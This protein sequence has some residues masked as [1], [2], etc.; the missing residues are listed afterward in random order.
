MGCATPPERATTRRALAAALQVAQEAS[1]GA[2]PSAE[3]IEAALAVPVAAAG[4]LNWIRQH[5]TD[6]DYY[7]L[8]RKP[9]RGSRAT[10]FLVLADPKQVCLAAPATDGT[11]P[12]NTVR[13]H[14][15]HRRTATARTA[16]ISSCSAC[17][18]TATVRSGAPFSTSSWRASAPSAGPRQTGRRKWRMWRST[19]CGAGACCH[20]TLRDTR[21][22]IH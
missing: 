5:L 12:R 22:G 16:N 1:S 21:A 4:L 8:A 9:V 7:R 11:S 18:S 3:A 19:S 10:P 20:L 13:P 17:L 15:S 2:T 6:P 14:R